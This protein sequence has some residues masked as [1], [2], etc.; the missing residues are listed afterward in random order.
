MKL[1]NTLGFILCLLIGFTI[2][3]FNMMVKSIKKEK[4]IK[5]NTQQEFFNSI[6]VYSDSTIIILKKQ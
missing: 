3:T 2:G 5:Q 1:N 6:V 4:E